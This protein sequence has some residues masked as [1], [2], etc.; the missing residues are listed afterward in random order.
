MGLT[1]TG[2]T[3]PV[4][5]PLPIPPLAQTSMELWPF[6]LKSRPN[7]GRLHRRYHHGLR[8]ATWDEGQEKHVK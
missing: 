5:L 8:P 2:G 6:F 4:R 1:A 7:T 3:G